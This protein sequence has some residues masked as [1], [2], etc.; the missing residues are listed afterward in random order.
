MLILR[1]TQYRRVCTASTAELI[2]L[3][4]DL[5]VRDSI[6]LGKHSATRKWRRGMSIRAEH[7]NSPAVRFLDDRPGVGMLHDSACVIQ[8]ELGCGL[9]AAASDFEKF[10]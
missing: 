1:L 3:P 7:R 5:G 8:N 6:I 10:Q 4:F 9:G 2:D